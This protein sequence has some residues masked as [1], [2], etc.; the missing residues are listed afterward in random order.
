MHESQ[1]IEASAIERCALQDAAADV[2]KKVHNNKKGALA[3]KKVRDIDSDAPLHEG[4]KP[5]LHVLQPYVWN[6]PLHHFA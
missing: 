3:S 4:K 2:K 1:F 5:L 6:P